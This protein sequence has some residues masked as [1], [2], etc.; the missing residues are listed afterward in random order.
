MRF[1]FESEKLRRVMH[2]Q[3]FTHIGEGLFESLCGI[4]LN[5]NRTINVLLGRKVCKN[6]KKKI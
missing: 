3:K 4:N 2:I 5:F 6:C 1:V